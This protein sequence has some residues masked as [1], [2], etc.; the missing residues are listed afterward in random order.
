[1]DGRLR[2]GDCVLAINGRAC[3]NDDLARVQNAVR[4]ACV[5]VNA[6]STS[7]SPTVAGAAPASASQSLALL[8]GRSLSSVALTIMRLSGETVTRGRSM[9]SLQPRPDS[10][11]ARIFRRAASSV[12]TGPQS[13]AAGVVPPTS[14]HTPRR[15][16]PAV[17]VSASEPRLCSSSLS[18]A[19]SPLLPQ[20]VASVLDESFAEERSQTPGAQI[21][22][23]PR[24]EPT[25]PDTMS[26]HDGL[27]AQDPLDEDDS[28]VAAAATTTTAL[29][30]AVAHKSERASD[31]EH[32]ILFL[33]DAP[34]EFSVVDG[35]ATSMRTTMESI[36]EQYEEED[37]IRST[38]VD[39]IRAALREFLHSSVSKIVLVV[40]ICALSLSLSL[41]LSLFLSFSLSFFLSS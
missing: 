16:S 8:P 38:N 23:D 29:E 3:A 27:H 26:A 28:H 33:D 40:C 13:T 18:P 9:P 41:S 4:A 19:V 21:D 25:K 32:K 31:T 6:S 1:V 5:R 22:K 7:S 30:S 37:A 10:K 15:L 36:D 20:S 14:P 2:P 11:R 17:S 24:G 35:P 12:H 34:L 39:A